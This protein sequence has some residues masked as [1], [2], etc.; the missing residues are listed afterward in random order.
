MKSNNNH[1]KEIKPWKIK[2]SRY[3]LEDKWIKVRADKCMTNEGVIVE[4]YYVLEYPDWVHMVVIDKKNRILVTEQYRHGSGKVVLE[5]PCG[6][7]EN[8]DKNPLD[9]AKRELLEET[10]YAGDFVLAGSTSPNP[11][12]HS[13][14]IYTFLATNPIKKVQPK[15]E[16]TEIL[17]Y[18]FIK[19]ERLFDLIDKGKFQQALH[20]GSLTIGLRKFN[21]K[22][23]AIK[24]E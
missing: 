24:K 23:V 15:I 2:E 14:T 5:L 3:V 19:I 7:V 18:K 20:I 6:T 9:T 21:Q 16:Q 1:K 12:N 17:N 8:Q 10:G 22:F 4:P 13:N 11:A